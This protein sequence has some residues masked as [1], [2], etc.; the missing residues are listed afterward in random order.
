MGVLKCAFRSG[1]ADPQPPV[2]T[3]RTRMAGGG[4]CDCRVRRAFDDE[5]FGSFA[6]CSGF[7]VELLPVIPAGRP[8]LPDEE[9]CCPRAGGEAQPHSAAAGWVSE[10]YTG[11]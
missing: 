6:C 7:V 3:A 5:T 10:I 9:A 2:M 11:D 4:D 1:E 8:E